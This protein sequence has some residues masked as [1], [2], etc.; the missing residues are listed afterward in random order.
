MPNV[1]D[2][3]HL[4]F[5]FS[6]FTSNRTIWL[7][8]KADVRELEMAAKRKPTQRKRRSFWTLQRLVIALAVVSLLVALVVLSYKPT[9][10]I[11]GNPPGG[12]QPNANTRI[13]APSTQPPVPLTV[14]SPQVL[15]VELMAAKGSTFKLAD[16]SGKVLLVNFWASWCAPC[17]SETPALVELHKEFRSRGVEMIGL[18]TEDPTTSAENVRKFINDFGVDYTIGWADPGVAKTLLQ[19]DYSIPQSFVIARD[20]RIVKHFIGFGVINTR[21]TIKQALEEAL[22]DKG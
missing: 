8:V 2:A 4:A 10:K 20:G 7:S 18:S 22:T 21:E 9:E 16:F 17:R 1:A 5:C 6:L 14:L 19:Q 15:E 3:L 11:V 13:S 12:P